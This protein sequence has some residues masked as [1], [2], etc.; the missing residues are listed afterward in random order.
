MG[1]LKTCEN[2]LANRVRL[3]TD[4]FKIYLTAIEEAV[5]ADMA[6]PLQN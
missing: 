6:L 3:S 2:V 4:R 1:H 5:G